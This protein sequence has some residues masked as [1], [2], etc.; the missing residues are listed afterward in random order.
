[1]F[2]K[3]TLY[4]IPTFANPTGFTASMDKRRKI[5]ELTRKYD[6]L[7][8]EDDPYSELR[9]KGQPTRPIKSIDTDGRVMYVGSLSKVIAPSFRLGFVV[10]DK[11]YTQL[12]N[13]AK[14]MTDTHSNLLAQHIAYRYMTQ[15]NFDKHIEDCCSAYAR[16]SALMINQLK[17]KVHPSIKLSI[18]EGGLFMMMFQPEGTDSMILVQKAIEKGLVCVPGC[19]FML[20]TNK[21]TN[22]I[23]LCYSTAS[24]EDIMKGTSILG[25]A[26]YEVS[27]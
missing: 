11:K 2:D 10:F 5:Y 12:F 25:T 24:D 14:Q 22:A 16:R 23:R 6:I 17:A 20:D 8:L 27:K 9:Y 1:M 3:P 21:P 19:A 26:S 15:C 7:V 18:P 13:I 4:T